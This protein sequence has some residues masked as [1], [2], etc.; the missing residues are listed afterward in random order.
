LLALPDRADSSPGDDCLNQTLALLV[1]FNQLRLDILERCQARATCVHL[2]C[3]KPAMPL[4]AGTG[5]RM[6]TGADPA[7]YDRVEMDSQVVTGSGSS[8]SEAGSSSGEQSD[9]TVASVPLSMPRRSLQL[10]F[11]CGKCGART[12]RAS[13]LHAAPVCSMQKH[14]GLHSWCSPH[15]V[16][17]PVHSELEGMGMEGC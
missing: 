11:T 7:Q 14:A 10:Q 13:H 5:V 6:V 17:F 3:W 8:A 4:K 9:S 16:Y 15:G 1:C 2:F 12:W